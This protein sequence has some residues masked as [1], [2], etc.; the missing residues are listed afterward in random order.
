MPKELHK[1]LTSMSVNAVTSYL[2]C[3]LN[4]SV[5]QNP[6]DKKVNMKDR[7]KTSFG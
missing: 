2:D 3:R 1:S 4:Q 7:S 6:A 5:F